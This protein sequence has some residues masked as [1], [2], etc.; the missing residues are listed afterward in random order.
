MYKAHFNKIGR[1]RTLAKNDYLWNVKSPLSQLCQAAV[2]LKMKL[3]KE[4]VFGYFQVI[5]GKVL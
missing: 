4:I 2:A 3:V 1:S 5:F